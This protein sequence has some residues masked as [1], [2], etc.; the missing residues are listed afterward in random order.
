MNNLDANDKESDTPC[1]TTEINMVHVDKT[2]P[3]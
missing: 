3:K 1:N 2:R